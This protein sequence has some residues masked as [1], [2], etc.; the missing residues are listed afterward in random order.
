MFCAP[1][2]YCD[3]GDLP[4][5]YPV[6]YPTECVAIF[7]ATNYVFVVIYFLFIICYCIAAILVTV[8]IL[9]MYLRAES[10]PFKAMPVW[11]SGSKR[12]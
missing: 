10:K 1:L 6:S 5:L 11:V 9:H 7:Y 12:C 3:R 8:I 4:P 2:A